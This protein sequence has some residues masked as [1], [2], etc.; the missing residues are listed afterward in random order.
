[1]TSDEPCP[2][3]DTP[4]DYRNGGQPRVS[5]SKVGADGTWPMPPGAGPCRTWPLEP[6]CGCLAPGSTNNSTGLSPWEG[7]KAWTPEQQHAV[8]LA[9]E[10]LWRLT[11]GRY[12]LCK[13]LVRP[14]RRCSCTPCSNGV[15][16]RPELHDGQWMNVACTR[17]GPARQCGCPDPDTIILPGP[18][19][20]EPLYNPPDWRQQFRPPPDQ[21]QIPPG[22]DPSIRYRLIVWIDGK[23]LYEPGWPAE[24]DPGEDIPPAPY[25]YSA[26]QYWVND[27]NQL[28]RTDGKPWP[29]CQDMTAAVQPSEQHPHSALGSFAVEYWRGN[30]VPPGGRRA[31]SILACEYWKACNGDNTCRLPQHVQSVT[32]E[33]VSYDMVDTTDYTSQGR[34][35]LADVDSWISAVNPRGHRSPA[36]V[37]TPDMPQAPVS[38]WIGGGK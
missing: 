21:A 32:R 18:V 38:N 27:G 3:P 22:D 25:A 12:G 23:P 2:P 1:M 20:W 24:W 30:P 6:G 11:A 36:G 29:V 5:D 9:T 35:G 16:F 7:A 33:G 26:G 31:V 34:T 17:C 28:V 8:E 10:I 4:P 14:C 19:Y 37:W 15:G 13:E